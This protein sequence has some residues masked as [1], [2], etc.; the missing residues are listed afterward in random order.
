MMDQTN[1]PKMG[2][3]AEDPLQR[4]SLHYQSSEEMLSGEQKKLVRY[5]TPT[6]NKMDM[7]NNDTAKPGH[8]YGFVEVGKQ[9]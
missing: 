4:S 2:S 6:E 8:G 9:T 1:K 5:E 3:S 7:Q